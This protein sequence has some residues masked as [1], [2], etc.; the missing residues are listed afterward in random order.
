MVSEARG[1]A[2][3][4]DLNTTIVTSYSNRYGAGPNA[5]LRDLARAYSPSSPR[6]R[7]I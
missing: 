4:D 6:M 5:P 3:N 2:Q 1:N 7:L